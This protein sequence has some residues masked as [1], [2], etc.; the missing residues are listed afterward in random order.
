M[1][2]PVCKL[3]LKPPQKRLP[4]P[5]LPLPGPL[6]N[7]NGMVTSCGIATLF[8]RQTYQRPHVPVGH[9]PVEYES[10]SWLLCPTEKLENTFC[11]SEPHFSQTCLF[12]VL[13]LSR[14]SVLRPHLLH[15]YSNTGIVSPP[16]LEIFFHSIKGL[17]DHLLRYAK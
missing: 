17:I 3:D 16:Y 2:L 12:L 6:P 1:Q 10:L 7:L 9:V 13:L 4:I 11:I 8:T 14:N 5:L 15:L